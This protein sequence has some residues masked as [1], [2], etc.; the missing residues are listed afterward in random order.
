MLVVVF[1]YQVIVDEE[2]ISFLE[3]ELVCVWHLGVR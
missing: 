1:T 2:Y 3:G